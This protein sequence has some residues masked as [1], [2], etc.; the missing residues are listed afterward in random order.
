MSKLTPNPEDHSELREA[1]RRDAARM[2]E[3]AFNPAL[4]HAT[5]RR[6][7][8]LPG[9][10][11]TRSGLRWWPALGAGAALLLVV[12]LNLTRR[13]PSRARPDVAAAVASSQNSIARL[14]VE[15]PTLFPIWA[16]P[17]ASL[18]EP[19]RIPQ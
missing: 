5:M 9:T 4:H 17:T 16:S 6:V 2:P 3:P 15:P 11:R 14:A 8:A 10:D 1:L 18:L 19:P 12:V 7:R 13:E